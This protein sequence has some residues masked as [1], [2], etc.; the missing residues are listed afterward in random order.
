ML[1]GA[2]LVGDIARVVDPCAFGKGAQFPENGRRQLQAWAARGS[3]PVGVNLAYGFV[4][5]HA[6]DL[7]F[8]SANLPDTI[9]GA[10]H[11]SPGTTFLRDRS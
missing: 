7:C 3:G 5:F 10:N 11:L 8:T 9:V 2:G 1:F 6:R 4:V